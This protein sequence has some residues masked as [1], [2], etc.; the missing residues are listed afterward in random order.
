MADV[1]TLPRNAGTTDAGGIVINRVLRNT[2]LLLGMTLAFSAVVAMIAMA[3][4]APYLGPIPTL[5]GFLGLLFLVHKTAD[6]AW[7]LLTVFIFTGFLGYSIGPI[8]NVYLSLPN[9]GALVGQ[10]FGLTAA[11]F[12][13]LSGY[14]LVTRKD[15]SFLSGFLVVGAIVLLGAIVLSIF[16]E[17]SGLALA[18]SSA[19]VL[20]ASALILFETSNVIHGGE[21]NYIRAT[22][23]LYVSIYNLFTSLLHLLGVFSGDD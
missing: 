2:Y 18:I 21:T 16:V 3:T 5:V 11:A 9:G 19:M 10:A 6:S 4:Q 15:F 17:I 8:L 22:V 23:G 7:G 14:A 12:V 20:F 13:G 1:R